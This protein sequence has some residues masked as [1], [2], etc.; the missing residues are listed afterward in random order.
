MDVGNWLFCPCPCPIVVP[1][2]KLGFGLDTWIGLDLID[3]V[4]RLVPF[5]TLAATVVIVVV[6]GPAVEIE[7]D[8]GPG[9]ETSPGDSGGRNGLSEGLAFLGDLLLISMSMSESP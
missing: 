6:V 5:P 8:I 3:L 4:A 1:A 7:S 9:G 2:L